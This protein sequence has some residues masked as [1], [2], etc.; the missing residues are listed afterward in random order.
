MRTAAG[1]EQKRQ[2]ELYST[3]T[4]TLSESQTSCSNHTHT[5][6]FI[7]YSVT[8]VNSG[9]SGHLHCNSL[10]EPEP[11]QA[12][13]F[14]LKIMIHT[15]ALCVSTCVQIRLFT[16]LL[17]RNACGVEYPLTLSCT[18]RNDSA[19]DATLGNGEDQTKAMA[20]REEKW[21]IVQEMWVQAKFVCFV[22]KNQNERGRK[23][24]SEQRREYKRKMRHE[25]GMRI[26]GKRS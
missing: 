23:C 18:Q 15:S 9:G 5:Q 25:H 16:G 20:Q 2:N 24:L 22:F 11:E 7:L 19:W 26:S 13:V 10:K 4:H 8:C 17:A 6:P 12:C 1:G 3:H 14:F 21:R